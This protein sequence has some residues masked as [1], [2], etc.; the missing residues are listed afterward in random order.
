MLILQKGARV[1]YLDNALFEHGL[2]N[3]S[4]GI[5]IDLI[6]DDTISVMFPAP[7]RMIK[8]TRRCSKKLLARF[9]RTVK[10]SKIESSLDDQKPRTEKD[11]YGHLI[12]PKNTEVKNFEDLKD[13]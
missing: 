8:A 7:L 11:I 4:I 12:Y 5:I 6:D 3:G 1:M 9:N 13:E 2:Y 10:V